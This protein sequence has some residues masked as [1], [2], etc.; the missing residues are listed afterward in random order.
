MKRTISLSLA[1]LV[2]G[3]AASAQAAI[4]TATYSDA[5]TGA[6]Y[7]FSNNLSVTKFDGSLGTLQSV[8]LTY[9]FDIESTAGVEN[10]SPSTPGTASL[11]Q[12]FT[13]TL[14]NGTLGTLLSDGDAFTD[15]Q[16]VTAYDGTW[17]Y[18][19][20]SGFSKSIAPTFADSVL[21]TDNPTLAAFT[22]LGNFVF[23]VNGDVTIIT[24]FVGSGAGALVHNWNTVG[25]GE[26]SVK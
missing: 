7:D 20:A 1:G 9:T 6:V 21:Y 19:G 16:A 26:I 18:D 4:M 12:S 3:V 13:I 5:F 23:N 25:D 11:T 15:N 8:E 24:D 17:D 14:S 22:G 10:L 2:L